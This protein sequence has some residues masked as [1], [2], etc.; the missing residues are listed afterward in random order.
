MEE[1]DQT[2]PQTAED[3]P[4]PAPRSRVFRR[5]R[6]GERLPP[7]QA[8]RQGRIARIA[9]EILGR[10]GATAFLN[11]HDEGLGGRPLD[12]A[13][14]SADGLADIEAAIRAKRAG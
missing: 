10:D 14:A 5:A 8:E 1:S 7:E 6:T 12:L 3:E 9:F 11:T 13:M 4:N 2:P